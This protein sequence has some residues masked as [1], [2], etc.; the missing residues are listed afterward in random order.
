MR[1]DGSGTLGGEVL[2]GDMEGFGAGGRVL[3]CCTGGAV[4]G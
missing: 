4:V 3:G 2:A 1:L